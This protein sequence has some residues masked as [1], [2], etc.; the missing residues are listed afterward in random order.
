[1]CFRLADALA[2]ARAGSGLPRLAVLARERTPHLK[3][4]FRVNTGPVE[5]AFDKG[6]E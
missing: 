4:D 6:G 2:A 5:L 3:A 1:M